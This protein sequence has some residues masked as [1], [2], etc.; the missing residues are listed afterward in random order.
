ML[1]VEDLIIINKQ[2]INFK[3]AGWHPNCRCYTIP[4]VK[5]EARYW[6][7]EDKQKADND[8]ITEMPDN[9]K[10]WASQNQ[11]RIARAEQRGTQPY[12]VRDNRERVK[13]AIG[14]VNG[15]TAKTTE[16]IN[17]AFNAQA[18]KSKSTNPT[19]R[20]DEHANVRHLIEQYKGIKPKAINNPLA[21]KMSA[22]LTGGIATGTSE[23]FTA[24]VNAY[25]RAEANKQKV[26][27]LNQ[28]ISESKFTRLDYHSPQSGSIFGMGIDDFSLQL[29][30]KELPK[31]LAISKKLADNGYDVFLLANP[32]STKSADFIL[33]KNKKLYYVEGKTMN[34]ANSLDHLLNKGSQQADI[35]VVDVI[36]TNNVRYLSKE[37]KSAFESNQGLTKVMLLKGNRLIEF[38]RR[39][40]QSKSFEQTFKKEW[41]QNK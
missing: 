10:K 39:S 32:N 33:R 14:K 34:G 38:S 21:D 7:D 22:D 31:N 4:I 23:G 5:G 19:N 13:Q 17:P 6:E 9:F 40:V 3:K 24:L 12:F 11:D 20:Q 15:I 29:K 30:T 26:A 35:V 18:S 27:I 16:S 41:N 2:T 1:I 37:L 8:E 28:I 36:G 25:Y